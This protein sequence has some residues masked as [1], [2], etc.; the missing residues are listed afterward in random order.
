MGDTLE[1]LGARLNPERLKQQAKDK[2]RGATIGR[3]QTMANTTVDKATS[4]GR[5]VTDA[6]RENPIPAALIAAG[7]SWFA[8]NARRS[9][10]QPST[11]ASRYPS[12]QTSRVPVDGDVTS[13]FEEPEEGG[14]GDKVRDKAGE[15]VDSTQEIG[16]RAKA[17]AA[18]LASNVTRTA[19]VQSDKVA[20]TF[21]KNPLPVGFVAVALGLAAGFAFPSTRKEGELVGEKRDELL[22]KAR[23]VVREKKEK[24]QNVAKRVVREAKSTATEAA[25][26]EGLTSAT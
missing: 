26:E 13:N 14:I 23:A 1:E 4:A 21:Q 19:Q 24:A 17:T 12:E 10:S 18:D 5:K 3:V 9:G 7:I 11:T 2:V 6:V 22:D 25:R 16:Q 15:A 8:F 20:N